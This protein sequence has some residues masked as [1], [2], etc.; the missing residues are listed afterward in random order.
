MTTP[1]GTGLPTE[2]ITVTEAQAHPGITGS[3]ASLQLYIDAVT[4]L[5]EDYCGPVVPRTVIQHVTS[6]GVV[7]LEGRVLSLASVQRGTMAVTGYTLNAGAGLLT[8]Y[9]AGTVVTYVVGFNPIP[10]AIRLAALYA[11]QHASESAS[12]A[13]PVS[14]QSGGDEVFTLS[15][16]FFLPNRAKELLE[17]YR[18]GAVAA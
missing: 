18:T 16:G 17:R 7:I 10:K 14:G 13:V 1:S 6:N 9:L 8:G 4:E 5:I 2:I 3:I 12:G 11:V 15:R